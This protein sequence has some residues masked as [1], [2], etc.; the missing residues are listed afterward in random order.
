MTTRPALRTLISA[1]LFSV[2]FAEH[3]TTSGAEI[4]FPVVFTSGDEL[5][6]F[7]LSIIGYPAFH[8]PL[9]HR[10]YFYGA[11]GALLT[12][13]QERL[14]RYRQNGFTL[15]S[16]CLGLVSET[17]F[18]PE[19]GKRLPTY[20]VIDPTKVVETK[21]IAHGKESIERN[22]EEV[23]VSNEFPLELPSC[24]RR[25]L[26]YSDCVFN[27]DR[28]T[29]KPLSEAKKN[30]FRQLGRA[31]DEAMQRA[32]ENRLVCA[33]LFCSERWWEDLGDG[34]STAGSLG[35]GAFEPVGAFDLGY[36]PHFIKEK[37]APHG[38]KVPEALLKDSHVSFFDV[39]INLP[40]GYGYNL[41]ADGS[42]GPSVSQAVLKM[43]AD[44]KRQ[45]SQLD[46]AGLAQAIDAAKPSGAAPAGAQR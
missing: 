21:K 12:V 34:Y 2:A 4:Q 24:F 18:D 17:K 30:A 38:I 31:L 7:G 6:Q 32:I 36:L 26:P 20:I 35:G 39:S 19:T 11:G 14:A 28:F 44:Q 25:G 40:A 33:W 22:I 8:R 23:F 41:D 9:V 29:G 16:L 15:N 13:S 10:C 43:A 1:V 37:L 45:V 46:P 27:F 5:A 3:N 42:A